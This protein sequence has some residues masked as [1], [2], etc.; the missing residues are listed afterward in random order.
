MFRRIV[1]PA[2]A[3][4]IVLPV[5]AD[6]KKPFDMA[7]AMKAMEK[8]AEVGAFHKKLEPL[9]GDWTFSASFMMDPNG[10][11]Q[12]MTG[13]S[14]R[15]WIMDG[16]FMQDDAQGV[17][18]PFKGLGINGYDNAMKKYVSTWVDSMTTSITF[19]IG[20]VDASG[21]VFT[22]HREEFNP[23]YGQKLKARDVI[24]VVDNDHH[25]MEFYTVPPGGKEAK[26]GTIKYTRKK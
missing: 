24:T 12:E 10:P 5:F 4:L 13:A 15:K 25:T 18:M 8:H 20:D 9:V 14:T 6:D 17:G 23:L 3:L 11:P 16:R 21:K 7:A 26:T 19:S 1:V 2:F 22:Y